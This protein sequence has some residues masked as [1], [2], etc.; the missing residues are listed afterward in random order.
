MNATSLRRDRTS[1]NLGNSTWG[2]QTGAADVAIPS[3]LAHT[4]EGTLERAVFVLDRS[5][6]PYSLPC[7]GRGTRPLQSLTSRPHA[8]HF[9]KLIPTNGTSS[10][11][12]PTQGSFGNGGA[13]GGRLAWRSLNRYRW[14]VL[15]RAC[16]VVTLGGF[17]AIHVGTEPYLGMGIGIVLAGVGVGGYAFTKARSLTE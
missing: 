10:T 3:A 13:R 11:L 17:E 16:V 12:A 1:G 9:T 15:A 4:A 7:S 2:T 5:R 8:W 14:V 6:R